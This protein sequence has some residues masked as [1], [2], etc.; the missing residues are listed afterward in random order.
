MIDG[1]SDVRWFGVMR[2]RMTRKH[3]KTWRVYDVLM[4]NASCRCHNTHV[5]R[6]SWK[7]LMLK[8][9]NIFH[10]FFFCRWWSQLI[11][12]I[13]THV[14]SAVWHD[15]SKVWV[16]AER[17]VYEELVLIGFETKKKKM[18]ASS[19]VYLKTTGFEISRNL[20]RDKMHLRF[21][22]PHEQQSLGLQVSGFTNF[23]SDKKFCQVATYQAQN[24]GGK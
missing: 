22:A 12:F 19:G 8:L 5:F 13:G 20:Q 11:F 24:S 2:S 15:T 14:F 6:T 18:Y 1:H 21:T 3:R 9:L 10:G 16:A 23:Y 4:S 7:R 17:H